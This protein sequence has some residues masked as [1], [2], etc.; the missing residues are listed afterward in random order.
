MVELRRNAG[1]T[2]LKPTRDELVA[3]ARWSRTHDP[4]PGYRS[5]LIA[6]LAAL[7][8]EDANVGL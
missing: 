4:S 8:V 6:A 2:A 1:L 5:V 7:G 3:A